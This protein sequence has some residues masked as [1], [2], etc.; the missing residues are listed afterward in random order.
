VYLN[1]EPLGRADSAWT[2]FD[3]TDRIV[4]GE[5]NRL[6]MLLYQ[7][8]HPGV[9]VRNGVGITGDIYLEHHTRA[10]AI[11]DVWVKN[12]SGLDRQGRRTDPRHPRAGW[13]YGS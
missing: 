3:V 5:T 2:S 11:G 1:G 7:A 10:P 4:H 12:A 8:V 13:L 6:D 9:S